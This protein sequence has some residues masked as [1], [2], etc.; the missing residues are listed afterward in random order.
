[1][2]MM[3]SAYAQKMLKSLEEEKSYWLEQENSSCIYTSATNEEPVIPEYD[4]EIVA[5]EIA[6]VDRKI[7]ILKHAINLSNATAEIPVGDEV[8]SVDTI[9]I[10]MAQL[11]RRKATLD[12]MR[13][14]LPQSRVSPSYGMRN[15]VPEYRYIN[16][17]LDLVK[18]D[19][20]RISERIMTLQ[21]ALDYHNQT[22]KFEVNLDGSI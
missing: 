7:R 1:M 18:A 17:D 11:N 15:A 8:L 13:K 4:Y 6:S 9:L 3:T 12:Y 14:Q 2:K 19:F 22:V 10:E 5:N 20:E 16:Y 21:M